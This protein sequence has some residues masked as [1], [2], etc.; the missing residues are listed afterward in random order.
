MIKIS[1]VVTSPRGLPGCRELIEKMRE[2]DCSCDDCAKQFSLEYVAT[3]WKVPAT[4]N[5]NYG[6]IA[7]G[8]EYLI[9]ID[10]WINGF[11]DGW[12]MD[13][14]RELV[15]NHECKVTIPT[16]RREFLHGEDSFLHVLAIRK[17][18][19]IESGILFSQ[20]D[21]L[22]SDNKYFE[23]G[24]LGIQEKGCVLSVICPA[25]TLTKRVSR[26]DQSLANLDKAFLALAENS[27]TKTMP[28]ARINHKVKLPELEGAKK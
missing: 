9:F 22:T 19:M 6:A 27:Q 13:L 11:Y 28:S 24:G 4:I 18:E 12:Q 1:V 10:E 7:A 17:S 2:Q 23:Q 16:V 3:G 25:L 15:V 20:E 5:F 21:S 14:I 26:I 8:G